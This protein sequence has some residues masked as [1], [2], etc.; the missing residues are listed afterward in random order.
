VTKGFPML[1]YL[2]RHAEAE[3]PRSEDFSRPLTPRGEGQARRVG[4]FLAA[5]PPELILSSPVVRAS[6]TASLVARELGAPPPRQE[7]WLACGMTPGAALRGLA[8]HA[9]LPSVLLVGHQPDLG[10]LLAFL[11]GMD[12][13]ARMEF[14]KATLAGISLGTLGEGA[15]LLRFLIP[16]TLLP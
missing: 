4:A 12:A 11:L 2:L 1:L 8:P 3:P 7:A 13:G 15:G 6:R 16:E 10:Q 5:R 14:S 9:H